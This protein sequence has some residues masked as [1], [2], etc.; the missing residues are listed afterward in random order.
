YS[1]Y[2]I[3]NPSA[4]LQSELT[5]SRFSNIAGVEYDPAK[6]VALFDNREVNAASQVVRGIDLGFQYAVSA[7]GGSFSV[8]ANGSWITDARRALIDGGEFEETAGVLG[9]PPNFKGR[10]GANWSRSALTLAAS[11]N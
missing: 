4:A 1:D 3:R 5:S 8:N 6:V 9:Y 7:F 11:M 10:L 2:S